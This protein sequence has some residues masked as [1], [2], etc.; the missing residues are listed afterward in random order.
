[1]NIMTRVN[2]M[3]VIIFGNIHRFDRNKQTL[4]CLHAF[5][6]VT[7]P[8]VQLNFPLQDNNKQ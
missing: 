5:H 3:Q 8:I 6:T 2:M 7:I 1:M 4:F